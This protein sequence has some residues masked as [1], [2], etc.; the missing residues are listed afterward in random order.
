MVKSSISIETAKAVLEEAGYTVTEP[1]KKKLTDKFKLVVWSEK[2]KRNNSFPWSSIDP[3][4]LYVVTYKESGEVGGWDCTITKEG[5]LH[6]Q[7]GNVDTALTV[8]E[9]ITKG[10]IVPEGDN[11]GS[12]DFFKIDS[13]YRIITPEE[14]HELIAKA[15][16]MYDN[17]FLAHIIEKPKK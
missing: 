10:A 5:I 8:E 16:S 17:K 1:V 9:L 4:R 15:P 12:F 7:I 13:F 2:G 6:P 11:F 14:L 3:N